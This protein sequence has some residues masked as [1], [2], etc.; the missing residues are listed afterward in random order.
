MKYIK[1]KILKGKD[2]NFWL[3]DMINS[4]YYIN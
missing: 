3:Q 2:V 1:C 4:G